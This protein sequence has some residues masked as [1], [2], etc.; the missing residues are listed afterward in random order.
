[1]K[2]L[3]VKQKLVFGFGVLLFFMLCITFLCC[4]GLSTLKRENQTLIKKTVA[5]TE[6]VWEMRRNLISEQRYELL[7]LGE[8][9]VTLVRDYLDKAREEVRKNT[10]VLEKYKQNY[11]VGQDKIDQLIMCFEEQETYRE[12]FMQ[13]LEQETEEGYKDALRFYLDRFKPLQDQQAEVLREIGQEQ[14]E[15]AEKQALRSARLYYII[16]I[17]VVI[18]I[19]FASAVSLIVMRKVILSITIP[20]KEI[21][22][23]VFSL[24]Q[25]DFSVNITYESADE[26]GKTCREMRESFTCLK[27]IISE[28]SMAS[29]ALSRG[30]LT[31]AMDVEMDFP[32]E[33][34]EIEISFH[35]LIVNLNKSMSMISDSANRIDSRAQQVSGGAH[36][37]AIGS[38][39]QASGVEELCAS[40]AEVSNRVQLNLENAEKANALAVESGEVAEVTLNDM[41]EVTSGMQ[42]ISENA[43]NVKKI[44]NVV[45]NIASQT[46][47]L[48]LNA[49]I[50]AARAGMAGK[51]FAV[52]A[53]E[54]KALAEQSAQAAKDTTVLVE[55]VLSAVSFGKEIVSKANDAVEKLG[56]RVEEIVSFMGEISLASGEQAT[57]IQ[58]ILTGMEQVSS[59]VQTNAATSEESAAASEELAEQAV[60]L[61]EIV[62]R[63]K[64]ADLNDNQSGNDMCDE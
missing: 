16:L 4:W 10:D 32:G 14:V 13:L 26:F 35:K 12:E 11:R 56:G 29:V 31:M 33:M 43:E 22:G 62:G 55:N 47:L 18:I 15:L 25:G 6:Y 1:M 34:K 17:F 28:I 30:D 50:E 52:V 23:A 59:V 54:I 24:S 9:D 38:T 7:T 58:E 37:L 64:L 27:K 20:L 53:D 63:F 2:G 45:G 60:V 8:D 21:E 3:K 57:A 51:G 36:E 42:K 49:T 46:N 61:N 48:S 41:V 5:N 39:D 40:I 19:V 44:M